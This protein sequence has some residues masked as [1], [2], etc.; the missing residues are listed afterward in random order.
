M[1]SAYRL[2]QKEM[3]SI[4]GENSTS[5]NLH[6]LWKLLWKMKVSHRV[7]IFVCRAGKDDLPSF[8]NLQKKKI[9]LEGKCICC[10]QAIQDL[11][12]ALFFFPKIQKW[13]VKYMTFL[14]DLSPHTSFMELAG[15][16]KNKGVV[17]D[18]LKFFLMAW[19]L[20]NRRNK[21]VYEQL[22]LDPKES[23]KMGKFYL[24]VAFI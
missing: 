10:A 23:W 18:F 12:H 6:S 13:W 9:N 7:R 16:V 11:P 4:R 3:H 2:I 24:I 22:Y 17:V 21:M 8:K 20:R 5:T 19:S 14:N 15:L 1:H